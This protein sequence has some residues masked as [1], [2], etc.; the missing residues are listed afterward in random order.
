VIASSPTGEAL[1]FTKP[2]KRN[3]G[4]FAAIDLGTQANLL[5]IGR[6]KRGVV[7]P[8][9]QAVVATGTGRVLRVREPA[10]REPTLRDPVLNHSATSP[11]AQVAALPSN[12]PTWSSGRISDALIERLR[13]V[14]TGF[15]AEIKRR[16]ATL[17]AVGA[18][19]AYRQSSNGREVLMR[20]GEVLHFPCRLLS[21]DEE[22]ELSRAG[23]AN[24][25]PDPPLAVFDLGGG[26]TELSWVGGRHSVSLGALTQAIPLAENPDRVF[27][28][29]MLA[30]QGA[31][32]EAVAAK[33]LPTWPVLVGGTA[34]ALAHLEYGMR[35]FDPDSVEGCRLS[36]V[37][38]RHWV[39]VLKSMSLSERELLPG[40]E[41]GRGAILLSGAV[42][43]LALA[44]AAN[45]QGFILSSRGLRYGLLL[46]GA[47]RMGV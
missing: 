35:A 18:T 26:S 24:L 28:A 40:I 21:G 46:D 32:K 15:K 39:G 4:L 11:T 47:R 14:L 16:D 37:G 25:Y 41:P 45:C 36:L 23:V 6:I 20:L 44:E 7:V 19:S 17:V 10:L 9:H 5:L 13:A 30:Y 22:A 34:L 43:T 12:Q 8:E 38:L 42:L 2:L 3:V 33:S 29:A 31:L 27:T 1:S